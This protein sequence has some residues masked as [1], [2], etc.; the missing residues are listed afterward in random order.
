MLN[1]QMIS[2]LL[3][4]LTL[5]I[6][7]PPTFKWWITFLPILLTVIRVFC[8]GNPIRNPTHIK[9]GLFGFG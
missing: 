9:F 7:P 4:F 2:H 3:T 8:Y 6:R 5:L 1:L